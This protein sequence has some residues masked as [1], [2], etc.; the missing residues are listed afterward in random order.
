MGRWVLL[1]L[2]AFALT[3]VACSSTGDGAATDT[4]AP[5]G[6][7]AAQVAPSG[8]SD[9]GSDGAG[10]DASG[11]PALGD[12]RF[13]IQIDYRF[14]KAGFFSDPARRQALEG[15][16]SRTSRRARTSRSA[17]RRSRPTRRWR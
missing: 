5:D 6:G 4:A 17:I 2:V 9:A 10:A 8:G 13:K 15:A 3:G 1:L 12:V 16:C 14:D 7:I 11:A